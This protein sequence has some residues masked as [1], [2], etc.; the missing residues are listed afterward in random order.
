MSLERV[1]LCLEKVLLDPKKAL[2]WSKWP[3]NLNLQATSLL[4]LVVF[5]MLISPEETKILLLSTDKHVASDH[6]KNFW[7]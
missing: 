3:P 6:S 2:P 7:N 1:L 4:M 5:T